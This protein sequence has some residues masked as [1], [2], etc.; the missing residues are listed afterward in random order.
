MKEC[1]HCVHLKEYL[2]KEKGIKFG[3]PKKVEGGYPHTLYSFKIKGEPVVMK[4][5]SMKKAPK[6]AY[7]QI[8]HNGKDVGDITGV[9]KILE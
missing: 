9:K 4:E 3:T 1:I 2:E 5:Y 6:G 7:P 8:F